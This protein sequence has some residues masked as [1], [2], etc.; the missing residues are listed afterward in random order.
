MLMCIRWVF[1]IE[2][3]TDAVILFKKLCTISQRFFFLNRFSQSRAL[4]L[5]HLSYI[6]NVHNPTE[7]VY[8]VAMY[9]EYCATC[10]LIQV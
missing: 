9:V 5:S 10:I 6:R 2:I 8:A 4:V 1:M 7:H 3:Q